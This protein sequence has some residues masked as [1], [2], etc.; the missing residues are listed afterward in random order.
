MN[1]HT[2]RM[3]ACLIYG[4][5]LAAYD[6]GVDHPLRPERFTLAVAL[7]QAYGLLSAPGNDLPGTLDVIEPIAAND[8]ELLLAHSPAYIAAVREASG[9]S[10]ARWIPRAGLGT[11]DTPAFPGM[12]EAA[13]LVA[14]ATLTATRAVLSGRWRRAFSVAGGLHHAHRTHAAG[15]CVY[16]DCAVAIA[17]ALKADP[18]LR[19]LYIDIDAHHGDGVQAAFY[20][21]PRV[22]TIS[23]HET[24][25][26]LYPGT[27][28]PIERGCGHGEGSAVNVPLPEGATDACYRRVFERVIEP[29]AAGSR[30][31]LVVA[32]CGADAHHADPLTS[33]GLTTDGYR[34]CVRRIIAIA[35]GCA[36]GRLV[37]CGGGGYGWQN[38][39]PRCWTV[40]ASE[41]AGSSLP[42][43]L[44]EPW[45]EGARRVSGVEPP[46]ALLEDDFTVPAEAEARLLEAT[47][48]TCDEVT[49]WIHI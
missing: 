46:L 38:V 12:H 6:L 18:A 22:L 10:P 32:Q 14:G 26:R 1:G 47:D 48:I 19:I 36:D 45:R 9:S 13:A 8:S 37:A 44:P 35:E 43:A 30:A 28:Y 25:D 39:V 49:S 3:D 31:D 24:G 16:N 20:D 27:G 34:D 17:A 21:D 29:A 33:L 40:L 23:V 4:P 42:D 11:P 15:F 41:L 2:P 7:M 5:G